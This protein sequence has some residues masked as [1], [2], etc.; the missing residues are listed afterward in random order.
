MIRLYIRL[1]SYI[2]IIVQNYDWKN[3]GNGL[4]G[5]STVNGSAMSYI[6]GLDCSKVLYNKFEATIKEWKILTLKRIFPML[7]GWIRRGVLAGDDNVLC[8]YE[9]I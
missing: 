9:H 6:R 7:L 8:I 1:E 4:F 5:S 3:N 2:L